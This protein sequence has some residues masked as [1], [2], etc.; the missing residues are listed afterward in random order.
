MRTRRG[1]LGGTA[2]SV[3]AVLAGCTTVPGFGGDS[4]LD[5]D[6]DVDFRTLLPGGAETP[7]SLFV[8]NP[9]DFVDVDEVDGSGGGIFGTPSGEI[10]HLIQVSY[11]G[12]EAYAGDALIAV[13]RFEREDAR[14]GF[15][16]AEGV[17]TES[18][19]AVGEFERFSVESGDS[20][21]SVFGARDEIAIATSTEPLFDRLVET[22]TGEYERL[23]T[24]NDDVQRTLDVFGGQDALN[25]DVTPA[26]PVDTQ[27]IVDGTGFV[28]GEEESDFTVVAVYLEDAIAEHNEPELVEIWEERETGTTDVE[29]EIDGRV[30]TVTGVQETDEALG[31]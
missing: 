12:D 1:V 30:V 16:S 2:A 26:P 19:E 18:G 15:E 29:S 23:A 28:Y 3:A 22:K 20:F 14:S 5:L 31:L 21:Y 4:T 11:T 24:E 27:P 9:A 17:E 7:A 13:G 8:S 10:T 25:L 6:V